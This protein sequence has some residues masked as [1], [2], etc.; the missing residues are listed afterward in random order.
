MTGQG[1]D[2]TDV[3]FQGGCLLLRKI[4]AIPKLRAEPKKYN[5]LVSALSR[6]DSG[7]TRITFQVTRHDGLDKQQ[8]HR[9]GASAFRCDA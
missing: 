8:H 9:R 1:M 6:H 5:P 7:G 3:V 4:G 2:A